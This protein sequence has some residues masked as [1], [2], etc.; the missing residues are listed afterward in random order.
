MATVEAVVLDATHL[1]LL[2]PLPEMVGRRVV[3]QFAST[4][5]EQTRL[6]HE[7]RAAYLTMS[8][9]ERQAEVALAEEGLHGQPAVAVEFPDEAEDEWWA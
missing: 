7:L 3:V 2:R 9:T 5:D 8:E 4:V 6:L 1:E